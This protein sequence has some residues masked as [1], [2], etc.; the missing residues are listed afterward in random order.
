MVNDRSCV[1]AFAAVVG[2]T[3]GGS[4][5]FCS[6]SHSWPSG[7]RRL[8]PPMTILVMKVVALVLKL[9][10]LTTEVGVTCQYVF[11]NMC[12]EDGRRLKG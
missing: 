7:P 4:L 1:S 11:K 5:S 6:S 8:R 10:C 2:F 12:I 3:S 9:A